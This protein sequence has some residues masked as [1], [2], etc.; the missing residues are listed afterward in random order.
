M[1]P[2]LT[3]AHVPTPLW[4]SDALDSLVGTCVWVKRDDMTAGAEA[5]NKVRKLEYLLADALARGATTVVTCGAVQSNHARAT[6]LC[7]ARLGL[8]C[9]LLLRT[10]RP[11]DEQPSVGNLLLDRLAGAETRFI[12]PDQYRERA[13]LL[14]EASDELSLRGEI[15][16][17]IP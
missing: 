4:R 15:A 12:T 8:R 14:A 17:V 10:A 9:L 2:R 11:K 3:L 6:A 16:Y 7:A 1:R 5:G 13:R